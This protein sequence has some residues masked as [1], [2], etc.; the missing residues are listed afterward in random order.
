MKFIHVANVKLNLPDAENRFGIDA[1]KERFDDFYSLID[2]C[3]AE[4]IDALFITG[5]L[6]AGVPEIADLTLLDTWFANLRKTHVFILPGRHEE[7]MEGSV[8]YP[9]SSRVTVFPTGYW[10]RV[11]SPSMDAEI[12]GIGYGENVYPKEKLKNLTGG[13]KGKYQICLL[14]TELPEDVVMNDVFDYIGTGG[15][16]PVEKPK[17]RIF[18]PGDMEPV[19]FTNRIR[20]GFLQGELFEKH[21]AHHRRIEFVKGACREY[22]SLKIGITSDMPF[23]TVENQIAETVKK[24]GEKNIYRITLHGNASASLYFNRKRL[25]SLGNII[26]IF[27]ITNHDDLV[28][29]IRCEHKDDALGLFVEELMPENHR[30]IQ[31]K[32]M[33]YGIKAL[34]KAGGEDYR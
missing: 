24:L 1:N 11:Y 14:P 2:R 34:L 26:E 33:E 16:S 28:E 18:A 6:F 22:I 31:R 20:H 4:D 8:A 9:W 21:G 30:E 5:N 10:T 32:A 15:P 3:N 12:L 19:T 27:D 13:T 23:S 17:E 7:Y 29:R 25:L